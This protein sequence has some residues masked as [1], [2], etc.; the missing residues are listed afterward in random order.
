MQHFVSG[1]DLNK[2]PQDY[3]SI[4]LGAG[5]FW[6]VERRF[7]EDPN[8]YLTSVGYS[9]GHIDNPTYK[10]V[11]YEDTGHVEVV[12][13]IFDPQLISLEEILK[14]FWECHDPSQGDRQ[15]NDRGTQYR[16]VIFCENEKDLNL[17]NQSQKKYQ[18]VLS[19]AG[20][21]EI[22]TEIKIFNT[23]FLAEYYHQQYLAKNPNGYCGLGGTGCA[24][25]N[26]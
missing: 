1:I 17:A 14:I 26:N 24:F 7:W 18:E 9:G 4:I 22:T 15:G 21:G 23:Y 5:C 20:F 10:Q 6:G 16:S 3:K 2:I 13:V 19:K 25:P 12:K 8:I 11:C